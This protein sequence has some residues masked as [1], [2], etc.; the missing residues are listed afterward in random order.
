MLQGAEPWNP[1]SSA[2]ERPS[3]PSSW[4]RRRRYAQARR[5]F[6]TPHT[7]ATLG[8]A[9]PPGRGHPADAS[10]SDH[11]LQTADSSAPWQRVTTRPSGGSGPS[12]SG[13]LPG[14]PPLRPARGT[15]PRPQA[16]QA[17]RPRP[18]HRSQRHM[19]WPSQRPHL[20]QNTPVPKHLAQSGLWRA[21]PATS[22]AHQQAPRISPSP[23]QRPQEIQASPRHRAQVGGLSL[24]RRQ[25][26]CRA[27]DGAL[28]A[29]VSLTAAVL[30]P[31]GAPSLPLSR[32]GA[33]TPPAAA[34]A[35]APGIAGRWLLEGNRA[36]D[37]GPSLTVGA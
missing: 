37:W 14:P 8:A 31:A 9:S 19:P 35:L 3:S 36:R 2:G 30:P 24:Q 32:I 33:R 23:W 27:D 26:G 16:P 7:A 29:L 12:R 20:R 22:R 10:R 17:K 13:A 34:A 6:S 1:R 18:L 25:S 28:P 5:G 11:S 21:R 15:W 4:A